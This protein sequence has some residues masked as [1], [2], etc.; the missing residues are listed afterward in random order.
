[1]VVSRDLEARPSSEE[2]GNHVTPA[3]ITV[4]VLLVGL[5]HAGLFKGSPLLAWIPMDLTLLLA[6]MVIVAVGLR[7]LRLGVR[8]RVNGCAVLIIASFLPAWAYSASTTY[9]NDKATGMVVTLI[10]VLGSAVLVNSATRRRLWIQVLVLTSIIAL[11]FAELAP[12]VMSS[13]RLALAGSN[14]IAT[15][16]IF[17]VALV[18]LVLLVLS[19]PGRWLP[20][21]LVIGLTLALT[22]IGTGSRGPVV[23]AGISLALVSISA[24]SRQRGARIAG[25]ALFILAGWFFILELASAGAGRLESSWTGGESAIGTREGVWAG[26]LRALSN[27]FGAGWGRFGEVL[28]PSE[29]LAQTDR[30]YAHNLLLEVGSEGGWLPL[31]ATLVLLVSSFRA[32][33]Q[34]AYKPYDLAVYGVLVFTVLNAMVSGDVNDNRLMW[35]AVV[36]CF[37]HSPS[38]GPST[39]KARSVPML[40][41]RDGR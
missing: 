27:P 37:W 28:F 33:R 9:A 12:A 30:Q 17:G 11:V 31:I 22:M 18:V 14:T 21:Q 35:C 3:D 39:A 34:N 23:A 40:L 1:M 41:P 13:G 26:A 38:N 5:V 15:G 25:A 7:V 29:I 19:S 6:G 24:P 10:A 32:A 2:I 36:I 16:R 4:T 8:L 20:L